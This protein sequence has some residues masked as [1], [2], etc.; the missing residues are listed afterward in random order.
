MVSNA[1]FPHSLYSLI[2]FDRY[3]LLIIFGILCYLFYRFFLQDVSAERHES[4]R[5]HFKNLIRNAI[6]FSLSFILYSVCFSY[7]NESSFFLK[8]SPSLASLTFIT[9]AIVFVKCSRL[10]I[11]Q[12]LFLNSLRAGVPLLLVN[13]FSLLLSITIIFWSLSQLFGINLTPLLATS[14][15][16]SVILGLAMQDTLGNLF[17]GISLQVDKTFEIDDWLEVQNGLIK[18]TGQVKEMTWRSTV[19]CGLTDEMITLPNKLIASCQVSNFS[20]DKN[21]IIRSQIFRIKLNQDSMKAKELIETAVSQISGIRGIPSPYAYIQEVTE[22]WITIK[23]IYFI[24]NYGSQWKL[25]DKIFERSLHLLK[26]NG[27]ELAK[28]VIEYQNVDSKNESKSNNQA[29]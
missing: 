22:S 8:L 1:V 21:P 11:L 16:F 17:A 13:I 6:V 18:I 5:N 10:F 20:P 28:Q 3:I 19:L 29:N 9:G 12:Y 15:A 26:Q 25:G 23:V 24:D 4:L 27:I 14:A 7:S 2:D